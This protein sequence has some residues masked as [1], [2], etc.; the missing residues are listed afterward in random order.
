MD[1]FES[2]DWIIVQRELFDCPQKVGVVFG[3]QHRDW[4]ASSDKYCSDT[5]HRHWLM[6]QMER[7]AAMPNI[8]VA[9]LALD[10]A[11][12]QAPTTAHAAPARDLGQQGLAPGRQ[13]LRGK[14][15]QLAASCA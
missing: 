15:P 7:C 13:T 5:K 11:R 2:L 12:V 8:E 3:E 14:R 1:V 9:H 6:P 4:L 10:A